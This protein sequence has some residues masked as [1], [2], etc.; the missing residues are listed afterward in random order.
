[1]IF[2]FHKPK[3]KPCFFSFDTFSVIIL[4]LFTPLCLARPL[5]VFVVLAIMENQWK[6]FMTTF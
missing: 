5:F 3:N 6:T 1:M 2:L 4:F